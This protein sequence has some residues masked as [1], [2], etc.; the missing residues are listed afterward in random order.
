[1]LV[2]DTDH[3][4]ELD[5][6]GAVGMA[7]GRRLGASNDVVATTIVSAEEQLRGWLAQIH[8]AKDPHGL[9]PHYSRLQ[10]R[11]E[12]FAAGTVL[13]WDGAAAE[14]YLGLRAEKIRIGTMDLKIASIV[15]ANGALLLSRNVPDFSKVPGLRVEDWLSQAETQGE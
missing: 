3:L 6:A 1:M 4:S 10:A 9:I 11:I 12:F 13:P 7:L 14:I 5:R 15:L 8:A 2:L